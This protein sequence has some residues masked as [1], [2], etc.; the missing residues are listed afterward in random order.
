MRSETE[1]DSKNSLSH[2]PHFPP[3]PQSEPLCLSGVWRMDSPE[4]ADRVLS[5][6]EPGYV[7]RRDGHP[8]ATSLENKLKSLHHADHAVLTAQGMSAIALVAL[9]Y[10][11][12]GDRVL[13]GQPLYGRTSVLFK[14]DFAKW[15]IVCEDVHAT[16]MPAWEAAFKTPARLVIIETITNPCLSVPDIEAVARLAHACWGPGTV[17]DGALV[18]VDNTFATPSL[19]KPLDLGADLVMESLT[20]F[21]CGHSDALLGL[22]CGSN[23]LWGPILPT[24]SSFGFTSSPLDCWLTHRGLASLD[25]RMAHASESALQ[26]AKTLS[27]HQAIDRMNYP[28]LEAYENHEIA[29][30][31]FAGRFGN[32]VTF[33]LRGGLDAAIK[34]IRAVSKDIPFCPSLGESQTTLSHPCSTSHR[35][36]TAEQLHPLGID[37]GTIRLSVGLE[38]ADWVIQAI[39]KALDAVPR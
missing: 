25:V 7:Y 21:V 9:A 16:H 34:F 13:L 27:A 2:V 10:L 23:A 11:K 39:R 33:S 37:G 38:S 24:V 35:S 22:L 36:L 5:G 20:K 28:G 12:P 4:Q 15:G 32:M 26:L 30:R 18:L 8:N 6:K 3:M 14:K 31:Q 17:D 1:L 19:C 29:K